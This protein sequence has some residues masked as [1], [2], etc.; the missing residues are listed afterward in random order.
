MGAPIVVAPYDPEWPR[1]FA[2]LREQLWPAV[3]DHALAVEHVGSTSVPGLAAKPII[4]LDIVIGSD[5][6]LAPVSAALVALGYRAEGDLGI[7]DRYAFSAPEGAPRQHLYVCLSGSTALRNHLAVRDFLRAHPEEAAA[8]G[9]LKLELA[10]TAPDMDAYVR[11][12]TA[13]VLSVLRQAG[14]D[15]EVLTSIAAANLARTVRT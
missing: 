3:R 11:G 8:Y 2:Q 14:L 13:F 4:D 5:A 7:P 1:T 6:E 10:R 12:K 15:E 9:A